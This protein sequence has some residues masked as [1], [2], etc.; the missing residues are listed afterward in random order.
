MRQR[1]NI[2]NLKKLIYVD[3]IRN[4][5]NI[6]RILYQVSNLNA[7]CLP[8]DNKRALDDKAQISLLKRTKKSTSIS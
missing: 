3:K 1:K 2:L 7:A 6:P 8:G 4:L 5:S